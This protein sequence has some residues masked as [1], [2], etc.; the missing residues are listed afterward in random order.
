MGWT[1]NCV[2]YGRKNFIESLTGKQH[3]SEGFEPLAHRVVGNHVWQAVRTPAGRVMITLDL[4]AKERGGGWGYKGMTEDWGPYHYDCPLSLLDMCTETD[5]ENAN[6]WRA[7]VREWH[8]KRKKNAKPEP[9]LRVS[10]GGRVY[11]L[12]S[13]WAPRKGWSVKDDLGNQYRMKARQVAEALRNP[14]PN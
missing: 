2:D 13:T 14:L 1:F 11:T 10:Y 5:N 12:V 6:A 3:F 8:E 9:G 7:K 4:I